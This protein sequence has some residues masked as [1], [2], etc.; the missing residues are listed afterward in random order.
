MRNT[1]KAEAKK[2]LT[3]KQLKAFEETFDELTN[4][5]Q[6]TGTISLDSFIKIIGRPPVIPQSPDTDAMLEAWEERAVYSRKIIQL[7]NL[8]STEL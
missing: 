2:I 1:T 7:E 3:P 5:L 8:I 4:E 6:H